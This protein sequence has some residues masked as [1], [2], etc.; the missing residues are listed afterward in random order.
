VVEVASDDGYVCSTAC[1]AVSAYS[2]WSRPRTSARWPMPGGIH[3]EVMFLGDETG[4]KLAD[5][6]SKTDL[7]G[8]QQRLHTRPRGR[9]LQQ[10]ATRTGSRHRLRRH[11]GFP[12][13][14]KLIEGPEYNT[15]YHKHCS[16]STLLTTQRV[17][18]TSGLTVVDVE[19]LPM[20]GALCERGPPG[21]P[22]P[23]SSSCSLYGA[24]GEAP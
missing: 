11:R 13:L 3:T 20:H 22:T 24:V 9:G 4:I 19:E 6:H 18:A 12:H 1:R 15:I 5:V 10:R 14:L 21:P 23:S 2:G 7:G 16:Y 17:L 8:C